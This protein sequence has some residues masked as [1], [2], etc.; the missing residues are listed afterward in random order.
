MPCTPCCLRGAPRECVYTDEGRRSYVI[1]SDLVKEL[2]EE[3]MQLENRLAELETLSST[4]MEHPKG[5]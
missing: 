2:T 1:Q 4:S 3:C 5:P